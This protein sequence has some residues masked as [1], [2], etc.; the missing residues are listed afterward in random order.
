MSQEQQSA[1]FQFLS[2][3]A[4]NDDFLSSPAKNVHIN[5]NT[6]GIQRSTAVSE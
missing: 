3:L 5:K 6:Y 2:P 1:Q 4:W